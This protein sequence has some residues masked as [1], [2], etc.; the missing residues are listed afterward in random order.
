[1]IITIVFQGKSY[2]IMVDPHNSIFNTLL[3]LSE[4]N[5][6]PYACNAIPNCVFSERKKEEVN[7]SKTY[8]EMGIY[9]GDILKLQ[10]VIG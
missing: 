3:V 1:M 7:S 6:I 10:Q 2:D 9:N 8:V 5:M 4:K